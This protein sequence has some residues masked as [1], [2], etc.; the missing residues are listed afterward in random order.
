MSVYDDAGAQWNV[1]PLLLQAI[2]Q[3]ESRGN[4]NAVS[5]AG[6]QGN[7][8]F[9]PATADSVGV[10]NPKVPAFSVPGTAKLLND[11]LNGPAKGDVTTAL[12]I[13]HGG[14]DK[15]KWGPANAAYAPQVFAAYNALKKG[16]PPSNVQP[17]QNPATMSDDDL[18]KMLSGPSP[19][20]EG[21]IPTVT[22]TAKA[23]KGATLAVAPVQPPDVSAMSDDDLHKMLVGG[24]KAETTPDEAAKAAP[25]TTLQKAAGFV[26]SMVHGASMGLN[27]PLDRL[28]ASL[29]PNS[30]FAKMQQSEDA[31]RAQ[32]QQNNP[33]LSATGEA[34]GSIPAYTAGLGA[35]ERV[36]PAIANPGLVGKAVNLGA[37]SLRN[38]VVGG[39][40]SAAMSD[41]NPLAAGITGSAVGAAVPP[42]L[43]GAGSILSYPV[44]AILGRLSGTIADNQALAATYKAMVRDGLSPDEISTRLQQLGP[45]AAVVDA[46][47]ANMRNLGEVAANSPGEA[48][49]TAQ[50]FLEGRAEGQQG[51]INSAITAAT[52]STGDFHA[53]LSDL[54][55]QRATA[56]APLYETAFNRVVTPDEAANV[57]RFIA[58]P[59]GQDALNKGMRSIQLEKLASGEPFNPADY[60][61]TRGADGKYALEGD[62]PNLRLMDAVKRGYDNVVEGFRDPVTE[63]LSSEGRDVNNVRAAYV[64]QLRNTF[65]E[66]GAALDA[67]AGPS[68]A[69]DALRLG[70]DALK[71]DPEITA[72]T[73]GKLPDSDK[74]F[75]LNGVARAIKDKV[76]GA[77]DGADA[78]RR[79][80]GN[81]LIRN[82]IRAAFGNDAAFNQFQNTMEQEATFAKT[83]NDVLKNSATARR[84]AGQADESADLVT[85]VS[86]L[87]HGNPLAAAT[88][89]GH[90]LYS[91]L[92][93]QAAPRYSAALGQHLF[94]PGP[95]NELLAALAKNRNPLMGPLANRLGT[96]E[97][98]RLYGGD[99][100]LL[101]GF[102]P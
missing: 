34:V 82:K 27:R 79:I 73:I 38:A 99:Q 102:V 33:I 24:D 45:N 7:M 69:M 62:T 86:L 18:H 90:Q 8:Q 78:T 2:E 12:R 13:Y 55:Q 89:V 32:F 16:A 26:D 44:K 95:N 23:P 52:G 76:E 92:G 1:D 43:T 37:T 93:T 66:Y 77:Q 70:R 100:N 29:F 15:S 50:Q 61:V 71:N 46:G 36:I 85:P 20:A 22:V 54:S 68:R 101:P 58:D 98:N 53:A 40:G 11:T 3:V 48:A 42:I 87:M 35:M 65:P 9:M 91:S 10:A 28:T 94:T 64:S 83:R 25:S 72:A 75:F 4:P 31:Q 57:Q 88:N 21:D 80:F 63:K 97:V 19:A 6:A 5:S 56:A 51:R 67:W 74:D 47:G 17:A 84:V 41:D 59:I 14:I 96:Q 60:G 81:T 30:G 39:A 49:N